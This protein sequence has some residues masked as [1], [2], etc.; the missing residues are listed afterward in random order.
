MNKSV[1]SFS[2][3][4]FLR[5]Q[6]LA[7]TGRSGESR[8]RLHL[9]DSAIQTQSISVAGCQRSADGRGSRELYSRIRS[10]AEAVC[11]PANLREAGS[12]SMASRNRKCYNSAVEEAVSQVQSRQLAALAN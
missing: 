4:D 11:G 12:L 2:W 3:R 7:D 6:R 10:A 5:S 9:P 8:T 1:I